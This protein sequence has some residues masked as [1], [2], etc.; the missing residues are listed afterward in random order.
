MTKSTVVYEE[1]IRQKV[2]ELKQKDWTV[3]KIKETTGVS[4]ATQRRYCQRLKKC[5]SLGV[6]KPNRS[7]Y[8]NGKSKITPEY[9]RLLK[10]SV[11][12]ND[13]LNT[14]ERR[15]ELNKKTGICLWKSRFV[16]LIKDLN[17]IKKKKPFLYEDASLPINQQRREQFIKDHA[18][19]KGIKSLLF[20][21][22]TDENGFDNQARRMYG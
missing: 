19:K 17:I 1:R 3:Y 14:R 12:Q 2:V 20:S 22:S 11:V 13:S 6:T 9:I 7:L 15:E 18:P 8:N 4:E 21:C 5:I 16:P 10:E